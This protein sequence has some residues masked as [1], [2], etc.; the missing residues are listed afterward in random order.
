MTSGNAT[1]SPDN[2][3]VTVYDEDGITVL[4]TFSLSADGKIRTRLT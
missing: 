2:L 3:S 1:I 4:A